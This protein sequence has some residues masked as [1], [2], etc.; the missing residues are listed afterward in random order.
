MDVGEE[1]IKFVL[2]YTND[3]TLLNRLLLSYMTLVVKEGN[4]I[5]KRVLKN[6]GVLLSH[7]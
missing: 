7:L 1:N 4:L 2:G 3:S 6:Y 5:E